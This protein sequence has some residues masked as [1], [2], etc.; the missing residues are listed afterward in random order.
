MILSLFLDKSWTARPQSPSLEL[1]LRAKESLVAGKGRLGILGG[2]YNPIT[3]AH[4]ILAKATLTQF[5]LHE[6]IFV[7]SKMP[8]QKSLVGASIDQRLEM[9]R[10]SVADIPFISIG[11]CSH[12]LFLD[13]AVAL[14]R[15]YPQDSDFF[16]IAGRDAAERILTWPYDEPA[17]ALRQMFGAFQLVV[18]ERQGGF[19][20]PKDPLIQQYAG[21][22]H[23]LSLAENFDHVSS[24]RVRQLLRAGESCEDLLPEEVLAY[25]QKHKLYQDR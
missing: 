23:P 5:D 21:R 4:L 6:V 13:I 25:I 17:E 3:V 1:I 14:Q 20:L 24:T 10:M 16:F 22:I 18:V 12:G 11:L 15:V 8:P 7:L 2:A 19:S 9:M